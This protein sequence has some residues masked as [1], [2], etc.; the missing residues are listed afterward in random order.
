MV[1]RANGVGIVLDDED[2]VAEIPQGFEDVDETLRVARVQA[3]GW[4]V[5]N[6]ERADEMRAE[7]SGELNALRFAAGKSRG[8]AIERQVVEADFI[9]ELQAAANFFQ[10]FLG[11]FRLAVRKAPASRRRCALLSP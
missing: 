7:R 11:D 2:S 3:D 6:V 9:E 10:D 1:G 8:K 4:L 5:E